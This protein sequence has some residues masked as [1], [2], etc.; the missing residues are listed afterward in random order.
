M[1]A[2]LVII[3]IIWLRIQS[4]PG[5]VNNENTVC[6]LT[7]RLPCKESAGCW[8]ACLVTGVHAQ[9]VTNVG[10]PWN[11]VDLLTSDVVMKHTL[12]FRFETWYLVKWQIDIQL[13]KSLELEMSWIWQRTRWN[14]HSVKRREHKCIVHM[15]W[16]H[17][18][19]Y[20]ECFFS[21]LNSICLSGTNVLGCLKQAWPWHTCT[22][23]IHK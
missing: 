17:T 14:A 20:L 6:P 11:E 12:S 5:S 22:F 9:V 16:T 15:H 8:S 19:T 23:C 18:Q 13:D 21:T 7:V 3:L 1:Q 4:I 10:T 2:M